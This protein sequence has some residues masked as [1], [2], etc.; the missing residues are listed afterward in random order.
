MATTRRF[1]PFDLFRFNRVNLDKL[2]ETY[3]LHFYYQYM[4]NWPE[5]QQVIYSPDKTIMAY[6]LGK[7]EGYDDKWHGHVSAVTVGPQYRRMGLAKKLMLFLEDLS[8]KTDNCYFV[9]LFVRKSNSIAISMYKRFGYIVYRTIRGYYDDGEED[10]YDMRKALARDK[11]K[12]SMIPIARPVDPCDIE[13]T[14]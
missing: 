9:D 3:T 11:D 4:Q 10:A 13:L 7:S 1:R 6:I 12:R 8:E 14:M 2:T 5:Y